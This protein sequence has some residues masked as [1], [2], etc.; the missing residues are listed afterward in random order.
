M[1]KVN[2]YVLVPTQIFTHTI[3][4]IILNYIYIFNLINEL[5]S[6]LLS[7]YSK[8]KMRKLFTMK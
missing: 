2:L 1:F 7:L 8:N 5:F 3:I 4:T 6:R